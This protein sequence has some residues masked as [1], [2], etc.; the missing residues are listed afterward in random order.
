MLRHKSTLSSRTG[1]S[2]SISSAKTPNRKKLLSETEE[3]D[4]LIAANQAFTNGWARSSFDSS[5]TRISML[6]DPFTDRPPTTQWDNFFAEDKIPPSQTMRI[7][8][9]TSELNGQLSHQP[10]SSWTKISEAQYTDT[11]ACAESSA[12][13]SVMAPPTSALLTVNAGYEPYAKSSTSAVDTAPIVDTQVN[14]MNL[15][16]YQKKSSYVST[17]VQVSMCHCGTKSD[18]ESDDIEAPTITKS[19]S[20]GLAPEYQAYLA[21]DPERYVAKDDIASQP[22]SYRKIRKVQS[23]VLDRASGHGFRR[24]LNRSVDEN[25]RGNE[26]V[27]SHLKK[28][29]SANLLRSIRSKTFL[30]TRAGDDALK[31]KLSQ[32][33]P[34]KMF[35][36]KSPRPETVIKRSMRGESS[37]NSVPLMRR[38]SNR[39][40][41][42]VSSNVK[43]RVDK[44]KSKFGLT[45]GH[46]NEHTM[47]EQHISKGYDNGAA[48]PQ[49]Y[50][51][52]RH[53]HI[54]VAL[55]DYGVADRE[56]K[57]RVKTGRPRIHRVPSNE[58][59]R[60]VEIS[61][62][63]DDRSESPD[64]RSRVTS[65]TDSEPTTM[66][67]RNDDEETYKKWLSIIP[68][69]SS[70]G[71][72]PPNPQQEFVE[73][74]RPACIN[75][76]P[77]RSV[78][79][80]T[81]YSALMQHTNGK[82]HTTP[83]Y[84]GNLMSSTTHIDSQP[85]NF[86]KVN[87]GNLTSSTN[88][89]VNK[90]S[91]FFRTD[92][93]Y[94]QGLQR[95]MSSEVTPLPPDFNPWDGG[96]F[97]GYMNRYP[98][99]DIP[100]RR[101]GHCESDNDAKL[102]YAK[103]I[104]STDNQA[105][106]A[107]SGLR[108]FGPISPFRYPD[109]NPTTFTSD[110]MLMHQNT[111]IPR[112]HISSWGTSASSELNVQRAACAAASSHGNKALGHLREKAQFNDDEDAPTFRTL[113]KTPKMTKTPLL[114]TFAEPLQSVYKKNGEKLDKIGDA[115]SIGD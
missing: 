86:Y 25:T 48:A 3:Q 42:K 64:E 40:L 90:S 28:S 107:E 72:A 76:S 29:K 8:K 38:L 67:V 56:V 74:D 39:S 63:S 105:V 71:C 88:S 30:T 69:S 60:S 27:S 109:E 75:M 21:P 73:E 62:E 49:Q 91:N 83:A 52:N 115:T 99:A 77:K 15:Q 33:K 20:K 93:A 81:L 31:M 43:S 100:V 45:K 55:P 22:S 106:E 26:N 17:G 59:P 103:S 87:N 1:R 112:P 92:T 41:R 113:S 82:V 9:G 34:P 101:E 98:M 58:R 16:P 53:L 97:D 5:P 80:E 85:N 11:E 65:W 36:P 13:A 108:R 51:F 57:A 68:E 35:K 95:Q 47:P 23:T 111:A 84:S 37:G 114:P 110:S 10:Q 66:N 46:D 104:Y 6:P 79:N 89:L 54:P 94:R 32:Y 7:V 96:F 102:A 2:K 4:A 18:V 24:V 12:H 70:F 61:I 19:G 78:V 14:N 50:I 44:F